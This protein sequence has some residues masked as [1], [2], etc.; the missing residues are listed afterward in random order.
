MG[1]RLGSSTEVTT[2]HQEDDHLV[3]VGEDERVGRHVDAFDGGPRRP[4]TGSA[5]NSSTSSTRPT[6]RPVAAREHLAVLDGRPNGQ[7]APSFR[8]A[9]G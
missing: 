4:V 3:L 8:R 2:H 7:P 5:G 6:P 9:T 1:Y